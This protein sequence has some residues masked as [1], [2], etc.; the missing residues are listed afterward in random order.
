MTPIPPDD[1]VKRA[2]IILQ[3]F[4]SKGESLLSVDTTDEALLGQGIVGE[5]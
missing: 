3:L 4:P 5:A 1:L 2:T